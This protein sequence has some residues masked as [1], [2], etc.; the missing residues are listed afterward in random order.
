MNTILVIARLTYREAIRRKIVMAALVLGV[1]FLVIYGLGFYFI[2]QEILREDAAQGLPTN[3]RVMGQVMNFLMLAGM[4]V[5]NFL[6]IAI[7]ALIS[8]DSL[9]GEIQSGTIQSVVTKPVRRAEVVAGKWLGHAFLIL[10]YLLL[11]AGGVALVV[12]LV[13]GFAAPNIVMG[14]LLMLFNAL[15]MMTL[16]LAFSST[17]STLATGGAVFGAYGLAFIGGWVE[18]IGSAVGNQTAI[19]LGIV[20]SL[21]LPSEALWNKA[22]YTMTSPLINLTGMSP[23]HSASQPSTMMLAY[24]GLYLL[25]MLTIAMR[26]FGKRDL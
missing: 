18:R 10:M 23:F 5:V 7:A 6:T 9:A 26:Q 19:D 4:Y 13:S 15:L 20:S 14:M 2:Q 1:A 25:V 12:R 16:T 24:A 21:L 8:A 22:S 3:T 17:L 11:M